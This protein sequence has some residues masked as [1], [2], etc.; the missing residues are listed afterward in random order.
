MSPDCTCFLV[1]AELIHLFFNFGE[2]MPHP[3][4]LEQPDSLPRIHSKKLNS[5]LLAFIDFD[6]HT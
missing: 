5:L 1:V 4:V 2:E 6:T 3:K